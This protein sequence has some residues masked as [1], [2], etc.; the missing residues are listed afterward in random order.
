MKTNEKYEAFF[1]KF[2]ESNPDWEEHASDS[3]YY[4]LADY[5][6]IETGQP[7]DD[8]NGYPDDVYAFAHYVWDKYIFPPASIEGKIIK[9]ML[10]SGIIH[11]TIKTNHK[12]CSFKTEESKES[13]SLFITVKT[14]STHPVTYRVP[15]G[16][17]FNQVNYQ[18]FHA[19]DG[20][21]LTIVMIPRTLLVTGTEEITAIEITG[22]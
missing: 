14:D 2:N 11:L 18:L 22:Q 15:I 3:T 1:E 20:N 5:Y 12:W 8:D 16:E 13:R 19:Q 9:K 6:A 10:P 4:E 7:F 17:G 21:K